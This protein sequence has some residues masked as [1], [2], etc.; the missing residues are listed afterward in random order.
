MMDIL[1]VDV[2]AGTQDI[3]LYRDE[4]PL[5][6]SAKMVVPS[7]TV[8]VAKIIDRFLGQDIFLKGQ[9]MGGGASM[10]AIQRH[11]KAGD[12]V[13]ATPEAAATISDDLSRVR[14]I[15]VKIQDEAPLGAAE[16]VM[17]DL[18][19]PSIGTAFGLFGLELP[20]RI[21]VA[22]QDHGFSPGRSNRLVRFEHMA[23]MIRAGGD[24]R[25]FAYKS[26]PEAMTRMW[27]V[28][29]YLD[30]LGL[31]SIIMD[32]GP[33]ALLGAALDPKF[34]SPGLVVNFGNGH[35]FGAIIRG[36]RMTALFEHHT[37]DLTPEKL[38][39]LCEGLCAGTLTNREVFDDGGHGA[40]IEE[41]SAVSSVLVTGPRR[42]EFV[43]SRALDFLG[44]V[45]AAAP[46]G[47]MMI[48]GCLGLIDAWRD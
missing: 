3:L 31:K 33:A 5:E 42:E 39:R 17:G 38:R 2:G 4:V 14:S 19:Y 29:R 9:T 37:S 41:A 11:L 35:T 40:Y 45:V 28:K 43:K 48:T 32:T 15:G 8:V 12:A 25:S 22:V 34:R 21:A 27:A 13:Y 1:A 7:Q 30:R 47:D 10:A 24:L 6:G 16:V 18:D 36:R 26:P 23:G 20:E 46:G 44:E